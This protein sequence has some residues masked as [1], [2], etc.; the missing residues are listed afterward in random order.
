VEITM[1]KTI[2]LIAALGLTG[3]GEPKPLGM[4]ATP[5]S[6]KA[7]LI[8]ALDSWKQGKTFDEMAN[9][10]PSLV[11]IDDD[12]N[13]GARLIDYRLMDEGKPV[14][15]GYSY[16]VAGTFQPKDAAKPPVKKNIAYRA[17]T[18]P[19]STITREDRQP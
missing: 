1:R 4:A 15:T 3:C 2:V 17:V 9:Q 10:S 7:A 5:E 11:F 16:L 14:G 13:R 18:D 19:K 8:A 12:L 6:S